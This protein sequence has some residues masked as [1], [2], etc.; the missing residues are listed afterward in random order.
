MSVCLFE[1]GKRKPRARTL[2]LIAKAIEDAG[3]G[4]LSIPGGPTGIA[5]RRPKVVEG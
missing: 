2:G 1:E 5:V 3:L 4:L